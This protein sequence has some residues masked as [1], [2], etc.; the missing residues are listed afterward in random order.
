METRGQQPRAA[1]VWHLLPGAPVET[2]PGEPAEQLKWKGRK[3]I[4]AVKRFRLEAVCDQPSVLLSYGAEHGIIHSPHSCSLKPACCASN[5]N[6]FHPDPKESRVGLG[7]GVPGSPHSCR[8]LPRG[9]P[10]GEI[11]QVPGD[12][13]PWT[14][15]C[16][17]GPLP[18]AL[19]PLSLGFRPLRSSKEAPLV[20]TALIS[21]V[22]HSFCCQESF[23]PP[24]DPSAAAQ[25]CFR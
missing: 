1:L 4:E 10:A 24:R 12:F 5:F 14:H 15:L 23:L 16:S 19:T 2:S 17:L 6:F 13:L 8:I 3:G 25:L 11:P 20:I 7:Q 18:T 22:L 9:S 21:K